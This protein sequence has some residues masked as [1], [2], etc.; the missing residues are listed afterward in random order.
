MRWVLGSGLRFW[1]LVVALAIGVVVFGVAQLRSAPVDVYPEFT[2]PAVQIQTEALGLSAAE[3]EQLITVPLEQDLLNGVPWLD[4]I[5]SSSMPGLSAIDLTF[6]PGTNLY[7]ARQMVQERMTQAHALPN[8]G[9]P[10]IMIQPLA[11]A[12][13]VAMVGLSSQTVSPVEMSVLARWKIRPRLM[14]VPGVANVSIY[15]Q[16][17]RQLQVQV[18]PHRLQAQHVT[19]TQVIK[20]A[21]NALW[22][23]PLTFVE[24]S[25][26]GT[27]GFVESPNQR[28]AI[29]HI[30]PISDPAQLAEV[31]VEGP[32][33]HVLR[34]G[35]VTTVVENHQPLIGDAVAPHTGGLLLA[36]DKFPGANTLEVTRGIEAALHDMAPGLKGV[37]ID[38]NVYRP[39]SYIETALG[40][41]GTA[42]LIA[43]AAALVLML[44]LLAS[45]RAAVVALIVVPV[46]L[47]VAIG[48]LLVTGTTF[49]AITLLGLAC[50]LS[51]VIDDVIT[52][53]D[54]V[55]RRPGRRQRPAGG[56][57]GGA[58]AAGV[59]DPRD[60]AGAGTVP[61]PGHARHLLQPPARA[62][63]RPGAARVHAGGLHP[64]ARARHVAA[65]RG[66]R[67]PG[68]IV[69][70]AGQAVL[71][72]QDRGIA[73]PAA[74][75]LGAR[76][77]ARPGRPGL[78]AP[79]RR[80][81]AAADAAGPQPAAATAD[82]TGH[83]AAGDGPDHRRREPGTAGAAGRQ[84][85]GRARRPGHQL[86]SAG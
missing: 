44:L 80:A 61:V 21:G 12:S 65:A 8:V 28:L 48:V 43:L 64:D 17:D 2:P 63:L 58:P 55:R 31:P 30:S 47:M 53:L 11:S 73:R 50:A 46:A 29:Q 25:T 85:R 39:A 71:R 83:L 7:A 27:G 56:V 75:R 41:V 26:P 14:G 86:R 77:G 13:R 34:L 9:S 51:L 69:R 24:A 76:R 40:N 52:D 18:D 78:R 35:D 79:D 84:Q 49:T 72:P 74:P 32:R 16:R 33:A 81:L 4:H 3:V 70:Q 37:T 1:R 36:I 22:V 59:R 45:W 15:G 66:R 62:H 57:R 54:T 42:A 67:R 23:S 10:P 5:H 60:P 82:G 38:S 68:W 19:L 6:Q 20:T